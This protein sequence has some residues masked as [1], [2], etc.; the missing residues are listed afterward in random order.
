M[1]DLRLSGIGMTSART[2]DRLVQRLREQGIANLAVL[3]SIRNVP[4]HI[5][6]DEALGRPAYGARGAGEA[7]AGRRAAGGSGRPRRRAGTGA[8]HAPRAGGAA[9]VTGS[10]GLR[11][12]V[13]WHGLEEGEA[14]PAWGS[15]SSV[16][17]Q[18]CT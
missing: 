12:V 5:F 7:A 13:G 14:P 1:T 3:D 17:Q 8:V 4:R 9:R 15:Y 2:R 6:I 10:G 18:G 11:A 16:Q